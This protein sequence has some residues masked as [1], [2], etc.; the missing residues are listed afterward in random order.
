MNRRH[1]GI[2]C[3]IM[4]A[5][6]FALMGFFVRLAGDL[7]TTQKMFFRNLVAAGVAIAMLARSE[8]GFRLHPGCLPDLF[9]RSICG[10]LGIFFNFYALDHMNISDASMLNKLAPFF[11]VLMSTFILKEKAN[12]VEYGAIFLALIGAVFVAKPTFSAEAI[13]AIGGVLGGLSAGM[14]YTF[15]RKLGKMGERGPV[16]IMFFSVFSCLSCLPFL[17]FDYHPMTW[18]QF[19]CLMLAGAAASGGQISVT[20]AYTKAPAK[21]ISVFDYSQILFSAILG[22]L[23]L[24]QF[25][26]WLSVVGYLIIIGTAVGK[27][28]YDRKREQNT[29]A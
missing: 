13:P 16:I 28:F 5:F 20:A 24:Q 19:G 27:W 26:D 23:F 4:A 3:I 6:F 18:A 14:A 25:P 1:Q 15:V 29:T 8:E 11:A 12:K 21:E 22:M 17:L 7:P 10:T 9:L 2:V